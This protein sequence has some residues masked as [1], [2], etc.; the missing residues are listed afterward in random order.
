MTVGHGIVV[1]RAHSKDELEYTEIL[2][3]GGPGKPSCC[4]SYCVDAF[5]CNLPLA[6]PSQRT[7]EGQPDSTRPYVTV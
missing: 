6:T 7:L 4:A 2:I 5:R 3:R 1:A